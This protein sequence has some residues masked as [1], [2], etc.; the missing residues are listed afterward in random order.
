MPLPEIMSRVSEPGHR[1]SGSESGR[2]LNPGSWNFL[3]WLQKQRHGTPRSLV[4]KLQSD[5]ALPAPLFYLAQKWS[6]APS[7]SKEKFSFDT[8]LY[9]FIIVLIR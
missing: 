6:P 2:A 1:A 9:R 8:A 7:R 5:G 4:R 3:L